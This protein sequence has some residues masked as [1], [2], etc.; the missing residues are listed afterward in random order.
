MMQRLGLDPV[1]V[2]QQRL[3]LSFAQGIRACQSC[4]AGAV[5][6]DW[7]KRAS[8][9]LQH[10]PAFCPNAPLFEQLLEALPGSSGAQH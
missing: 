5:C 7:L 4:D 2:S 8:V 6:C 9:H 1:A 3:G 10:P